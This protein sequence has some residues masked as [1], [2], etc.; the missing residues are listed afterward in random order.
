MLAHLTIAFFIRKTSHIQRF[1]IGQHPYYEIMQPFARKPINLQ[2]GSEKKMSKRWWNCVFGTIRKSSNVFWTLKSHLTILAN[3]AHV[4]YSHDENWA[5]IAH[6]P[7]RPIFLANMT[8]APYL[9]DK[10]IRRLTTSPITFISIYSALSIFT[11]VMQILC[12]IDL[13]CIFCVID[14]GFRSC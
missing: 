8:H 14:W 9:Q 3:G 12:D 10:W 1:Y 11:T 7:P 13:K 2:A 4:P 6:Y 5:N